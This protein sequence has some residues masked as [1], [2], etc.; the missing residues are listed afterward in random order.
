MAPKGERISFPLGI[1]THLAK[2]RVPLT[3]SFTTKKKL[4]YGIETSNSWT[5]E[6]IKRKGRTKPC[7]TLAF[8]M[9]YLYSALSKECN[10][11]PAWKINKQICNF[12][13]Q[14]WK[15]RETN[16]NAWAS[17]EASERSISITCK[18]YCWSSLSGCRYFRR[19]AC[20][21]QCKEN[22][23]KLETK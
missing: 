6:N 5:H 4:Q 17:T 1:L 20:N 7:P 15:L 22:K 3:N 21:I 8:L 19:I 18:A 10:K 2:R 14:I 13:E 9:Y 16:T 11:T 12:Y 23:T